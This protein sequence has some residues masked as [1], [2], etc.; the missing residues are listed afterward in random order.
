[1]YNGQNVTN[2]AAFIIMIIITSPL[3]CLLTVCDSFCISLVQ[4][5]EVTAEFLYQN[6][7]RLNVADDR[8]YTPLHLATM[9]EDAM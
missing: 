6:S 3:G 8:G 5:N 7:A 2:Y 4:G 1:M 9:N